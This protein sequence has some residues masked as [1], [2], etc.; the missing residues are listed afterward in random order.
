MLLTIAALA[1]ALLLFL[2]MKVR[3]HAFI[4]LVLVSLLTAVAAGISIAQVP[5]A[6]L[7][8]FGTTLVGVPEVGDDLRA[9][10]RH[11][12]A[13]HLGLSPCD[14][15]GDDLVQPTGFLLRL[16]RHQVVVG[17]TAQDLLD[18][19]SKTREHDVAR[20]LEEQPVERDVLL[21]EG[22]QVTRGAR[23]FHQLSEA[24]D[25]GPL[26]GVSARGGEGGR[27]GLD[28]RPQHGEM[29][30]VQDPVLTLQTPAD[31]RRVV[32]VPSVPRQDPDAGAPT[33]LDQ[34]HRSQHLHHLAG[35]GPRDAVLLSEPVQGDDG[36]LGEVAS[37]D[38]GTDLGQD[39]AVGGRHDQQTSREPEPRTRP[40]PRRGPCHLVVMGVSGTGKTTVAEQLA[41]RLGWEFIEGDIL[42]PPANIAKMSA[43][44]PLDD[45]DRGP[46]LEGLGLLL[47]SHHDDGL[48]SVLTCSALKRSYRDV[49]RAG[50]SD[51]GAVFFVHLAAPFE[52]LRERMESRKHFM[53]PSLLQSQ[54]DSLEPL[55]TDELGVAVDVSQPV[56]GVVA[57]AIK[58]IG[59]IGR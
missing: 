49:L 47:A 42:H 35:D 26:L 37:H 50:I 17:A 51:D 38:A 59:S 10:R 30:E 52:V 57:D 55:G 13:R 40:Y 6:R 33:A 9:D 43:G 18:N 39:V 14:R 25:P 41:E 19:G 27:L 34:S 7:A 29:V 21:D 2:I 54:L 36:P 16:G 53:P 11:G 44:V 28:G 32:V 46:W 5:A 22:P 12:E 58:A 20:G 1:V 48:S 8:G 24:D 15:L 31:D 23:S 45:D 4:A 3:L 56:A